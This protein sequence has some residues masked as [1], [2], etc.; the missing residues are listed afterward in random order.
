[1]DQE[2]RNPFV[3]QNA[4]SLGGSRPSAS[5]GSTPDVIETPER[6]TRRRNAILG[7]LSIVLSVA[8]LILITA[9]VLTVLY[10]SL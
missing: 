4:P 3:Q 10:W 1:M 6:A 2:P 8:C 9:M 5:S 7:V